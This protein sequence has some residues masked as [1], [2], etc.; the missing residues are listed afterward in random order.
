MLFHS[1]KQYLIIL[2]T[3]YLEVYL[4]TQNLATGLIKYSRLPIIQGKYGFPIYRKFCGSGTSQFQMS[5]ISSLSI[6]EI[7][8][9]PTTVSKLLGC[10]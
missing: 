2:S 8:L 3:G 5:S 7:R 4:L 10:L 9:T 6:R 1:I